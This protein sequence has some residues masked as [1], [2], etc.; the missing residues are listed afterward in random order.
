MPVK[1]TGQ[2]YLG[3][4]VGGTKILSGLFDRSMRLLAKRK[5]QTN[6]RRGPE[7]VVDQVE[8]AIRELAA[9]ENLRLNQV[10]AIGLGAPGKVKDGRVLH[11]YNIG[12]EDVGIGAI[13]R[14]RLRVPV[15]VEN[16]CNLFALGIHRVELLG[17][18]RT[19]VGLFLG[20]GIGGGLIID[21]K[22]YRGFNLA[23]GEFG[24]MIVD[25]DGIR[26]PNSF[27]GSLESLASHVGITR[28]LRQAVKGGEQTLLQAELGKRLNGLTSDYLRMAI[29]RRDRLVKRIV[30]EAAEETGLCVAGII[31]ALGPEYV[32][33]GGG[34]VETLQRTMLPV[35][36]KTAAAHVL[37]GTMEGIRILLSTMGEEGGI[38]GAAVFARDEFRKT[39]RK[40][41][42]R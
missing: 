14:R 11:A 1:W 16:D 19:M 25:K 39:A 29:V 17:K 8:R 35:I 4:D 30:C 33:L 18:P 31:S 5:T 23:A 12:W 34:V 42:A 6:A 20:T 40:S 28:R 21:G 9:G 22:L 15:F 10:R 2:Y 24:Q 32:M 37:P 3:V 27:P 38:Y 26:A 13:L 36:R 7:V 41:A